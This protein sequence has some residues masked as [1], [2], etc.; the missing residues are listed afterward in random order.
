MN[1][2]RM[3]YTGN[4]TQAIEP[5][6]NKKNNMKNVTDNQTPC[7]LTIYSFLLGIALIA[8]IIYL[9]C[10]VFFKKHKKTL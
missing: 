3:K 8:V 6:Y 7:P 4:Y 10:I 9:L 5:Y 1:G 2:Q